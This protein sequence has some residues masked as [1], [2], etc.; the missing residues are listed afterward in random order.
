[1]LALPILGM[2]LAFNTVAQ[3]SSA[4][5]G[6]DPAIVSVGVKS[7]SHNGAVNVYHLSGTVT[8]LGTQRQS[9]NVLQF[10][11]IY[12][13]D[14]KVDARGVPPLRPGQSYTF[15]YDVQRSADSGDGTTLLR[16]QIDL[17][18]SA[19]DCNPGNDTYSLTI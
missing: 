7:V 13:N 5:N 10:V 12:M 19:Q 3:A 17:R 8:N 2:L 14:L 18:R 11:D 15:G 16:F 1:M 6:P 4:C 9:S